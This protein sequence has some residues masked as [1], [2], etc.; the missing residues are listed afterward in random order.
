[1]YCRAD[2]SRTEIFGIALLLTTVSPGAF[3]REFRAADTQ[4]GDHPAI[5]ALC[6]MGSLAKT[7]EQIRAGTTD[8]NRTNVALIGT[9]VPAM[10]VAAMA[11]SIEHI[12]K[13]E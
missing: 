3:A 13:M 6:D 7:L 9:T 8:F 10:P 5:L 12:R 4:N 2:L 1:V 11:R